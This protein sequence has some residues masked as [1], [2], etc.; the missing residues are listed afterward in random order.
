MFLTC[1][2]RGIRAPWGCCQDASFS[3]DDSSVP[4]TNDPLENWDGGDGGPLTGIFAVEATIT[5]NAGINV[6]EQAALS[7]AHLS[8]RHLHPPEDDAVPAH[9]AEHLRTW[10]RFDG[11]AETLLE[12]LFWTRSNETL[13]H[14]PLERR[15]HR[16]REVHA[17]LRCWKVLGANLANPA[18]DPLPDDGRG[19]RHRTT[20]CRDTPA[21]PSSRRP[22]TCGMGVSAAALR[23][24]PRVGRARGHRADP[25]RHQRVRPGPP[26]SVRRRV[27]RSVPRGGG[28]HQHPGGAG[29]SVPRAAGGGGVRCR[30]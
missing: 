13:G 26:R 21:S 22:S 9:A 20:T 30:P 27:Q 8:R 6:S 15:Q 11:P 24:A 29:Q 16:R 10:S 23:R 19:R 12:Q 14:V 7:P 28:V 1:V 5:A 4:I 17:C 18:T 2:K 3:L 25:R